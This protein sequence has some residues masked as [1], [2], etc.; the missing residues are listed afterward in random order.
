MIGRHSHQTCHLSLIKD[1][2]T[3]LFENNTAYIVKIKSGYIK[4]DQ[5]KHISSKLFYTH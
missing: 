3:I 1:T 4:G 5:M 2:P